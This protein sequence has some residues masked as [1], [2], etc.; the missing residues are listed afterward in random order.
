MALFP[1]VCR[2]QPRSSVFRGGPLVT[3][4]VRWSMPQQCPKIPTLAYSPT[5]SQEEPGCLLR[6]QELRTSKRSCFVANGHQPAQQSRPGQ[7]ER[8]FRGLGNGHST[9][10][11]PVALPVGPLAGQEGIIWRWLLV[12]VDVER[13]GGDRMLARDRG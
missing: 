10:D 6:I 11:L 4:V 7:D 12:A 5:S 1:E 13:P 3:A 2:G 9:G 8:P